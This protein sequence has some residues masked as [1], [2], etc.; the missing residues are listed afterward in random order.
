[1]NYKG[2]FT[3]IP[4]IIKLLFQ[5]SSFLVPFLLFPSFSLPFPLSSSPTCL[6]FTLFA[7]P[8]GHQPPSLLFP[9]LPRPNPP[10]LPIFYQC[11]TLS[12]SPQYNPRSIVINQCQWKKKGITMNYC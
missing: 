1:M 9:V 11:S 2:F 12:F 3:N 7:N 4:A 8:P 5:L 10:L 6:L